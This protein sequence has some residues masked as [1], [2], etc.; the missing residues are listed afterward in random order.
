MGGKD[1]YNTRIQ[2]HAIYMC[3]SLFLPAWYVLKALSTNLRRPFLP[4]FAPSK[5]PQPAA[6]SQQQA[7]QTHTTRHEHAHSM[8]YN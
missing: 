8:R 2:S 5:P 1:V 4:P 6:S 7:R 3:T